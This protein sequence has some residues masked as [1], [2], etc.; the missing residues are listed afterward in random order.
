MLHTRLTH[1]EP[2]RRD[3]EFFIQE[4]QHTDFSILDRRIYDD[5][6]ETVLANSIAR[7]LIH[8]AADK[9]HRLVNQKLIAQAVEYIHQHYATLRSLSDVTRHVKISLRELEDGFRAYE[10]CS[11]SN[12]L[13]QLRLILARDLRAHYGAASSLDVIAHSC[14]FLNGRHMNI[15]HKKIYHQAFAAPLNREN[16][17]APSAMSRRVHM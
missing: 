12:Y 15:W 11:P 9:Q 5:M 3:V 17:A 1:I 6:C 8:L 10:N 14:G 7:F 13:A 4:Y 2:L 16:N